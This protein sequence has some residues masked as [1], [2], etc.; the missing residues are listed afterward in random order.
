[1]LLQIQ[2]LILYHWSSGLFSYFNEDGSRNT[3]TWAKLEDTRKEI[4][5]YR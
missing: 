2:I 1:M 4:D 5:S 3:E